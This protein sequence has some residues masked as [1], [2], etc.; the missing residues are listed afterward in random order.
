MQS[1]GGFDR[2]MIS[3]APKPTQFKPE[4]SETLGC[5]AV[6]VINSHNSAHGDPGALVVDDFL[7]PEQELEILR[8]V[9]VGEPSS[10]GSEPWGC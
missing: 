8:Q 1:E 7:T 6:P 2:Q 3:H 5:I 10:F 4:P 9:S